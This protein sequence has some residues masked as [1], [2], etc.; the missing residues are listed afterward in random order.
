MSVEYDFTKVVRD[1]HMVLPLLVKN[2]GA[3]VDIS[4]WKFWFT[5]KKTLTETDAEAAADN[6]QYIVTMPSGSTDG[7]VVLTVM[8]PADPTVTSYYYDIQYLTNAAVRRTPY[9]GRIL[10]ADE[11]TL[12]ES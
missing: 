8:I 1:D 11:R 10:L 12:S 9:F 3:A 4:D 2:N 7:T 6:R 5:V